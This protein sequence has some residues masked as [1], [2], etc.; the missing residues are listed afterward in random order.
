MEISIRH[1]NHDFFLG[2]MALAPWPLV[3]LISRRMD[4]RSR[5][6]EEPIK[7]LRPHPVGASKLSLLGPPKASLQEAFSI[8]AAICSFFSG[9]KIWKLS[10]LIATIIFLRPTKTACL[11]WWP[12]KIHKKQFRTATAPTISKRTRNVEKTILKLI[13]IWVPID[14]HLFFNRFQMEF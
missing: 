12:S 14:F 8:G 5:G 11:K 13:S 10:P 1:Q 2:P 7:N 6:S 4:S 9:N 3:W